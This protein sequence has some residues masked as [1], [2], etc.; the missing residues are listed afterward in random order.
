MQITISLGDIKKR[1]CGRGLNVIHLALR[2][3]LGAT[4]GERG[5]VSLQHVLK[6][7]EEGYLVSLHRIGAPFASIQ[8]SIGESSHE[9]CDEEDRLD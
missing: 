3:Y 7:F 5:G 1:S 4:A 9:H 2:N 6:E 8:T